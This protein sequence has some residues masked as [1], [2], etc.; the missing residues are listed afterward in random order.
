MKPNTGARTSG[1]RETRRSASGMAN[2]N[3]MTSASA[4]ISTVTR[5]PLK[6]CGSELM[7]RLRSM[8][9]C[10]L[11]AAVGPGLEA[12]LQQYR[13]QGNAQIEQRCHEVEGKGQFGRGHGYLRGT[14]Q[15]V[16][17]DHRNQRSC[18]DQHHPDVTQPR[19]GKAPDL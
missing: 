4:V 9:S 12:L 18:L 8:S 3:P 16:Q 15:F 17:L 1:L 5:S 14:H 6:S 7:T 19:E 11:R 13:D 2:A 10:P